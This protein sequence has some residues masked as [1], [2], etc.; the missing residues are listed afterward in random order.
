MT[1]KTIRLIAFI[2]LLVHGIGHFQGVVAS[3]GVKINNSASSS[4]WILKGMK[5]QA[6]RTICF[7]LFLLTGLAGII[8]ALGFFGV[9]FHGNHW[10]TMALVTAFMS[11]VCL[12]LFWNC[13]AMFF[14]KI[15]AIAVNILIYYS[16]LFNQQWPAALF[17]N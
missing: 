3:L 17:E 7:V 4:S 6:A 16:I 8:T 14:N 10:E 9:V 13:F 15:G 2:V 1:T 5:E 12:I 11:S